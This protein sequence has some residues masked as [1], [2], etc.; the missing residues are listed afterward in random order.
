M[1]MILVKQNKKIYAD[2]DMDMISGESNNNTG[3]DELN[4]NDDM[5]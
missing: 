2:D 3:N 5:E 4:S 1:I